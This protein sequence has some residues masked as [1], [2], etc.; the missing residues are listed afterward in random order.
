MVRCKFV[1]HRKDSNEEGANIA[2]RAVT[3]GS[4][5]NESFFRYTPGGELTLYTVNLAA[6]EHFQVGKEY[7]LDIKEA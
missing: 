7:Y 6:A 1:C 5:E 3:D 2:L 4:T